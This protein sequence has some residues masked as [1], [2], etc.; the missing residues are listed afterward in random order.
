MLEAPLS[1]ED[2]RVY[3]PLYIQHFCFSGP[4]RGG[5][6]ALWGDCVATVCSWSRQSYF[7]PETNGNEH[8]GIMGMSSGA[9]RLMCSGGT[10][11]GTRLTFVA[12]VTV[13]ASDNSAIMS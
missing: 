4:L 7:Y 11:Q 9:T 12:A 6:K 13:S 3:L 8:R 10:A 5:W 2:K 1:S